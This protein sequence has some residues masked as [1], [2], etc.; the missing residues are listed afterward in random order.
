MKHFLTLWHHE[1]YQTHWCFPATG[2]ALAVFPRSLGPFGKWDLE[3]RIWPPRMLTATGVCC[4]P[5]LPRASHWLASH[6]RVG[7]WFSVWQL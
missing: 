2:L 7:R 1:M 5:V 4:R 3:A 6:A